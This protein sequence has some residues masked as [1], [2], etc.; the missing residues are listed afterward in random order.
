V[1]FAQRPEAKLLMKKLKKGDHLVFLRP[2]RAFRSVKDMIDVVDILHQKGI[3]IHLAESGMKTGEV[4]F[5]LCMQIMVL[6]AQIESEENGRRSRDVRKWMWEAGLIPVADKNLPPWVVTVTLRN[7]TGGLERHAVP[8][9]EYLGHCLEVKE[10]KETG[11]I[12]GK[13]AEEMERRMAIREHRLPITHGGA[14]PGR[15]R[16]KMVKQSRDPGSGLDRE[17]MEPF[18]VRLR[19][20]EKNKRLMYRTYHHRAV[21]RMPDHWEN[22]QKYLKLVEAD[23]DTAMI[24]TIRPLIHA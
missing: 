4:S 13:V 2:A 20:A 21:R 11:I 23:A 10:L 22:Y 17:L 18:L 6:M 7:E 5:Q 3:T 9:M 16:F 1:N 15:L 24:T 14:D 12:W 19:H 8:N